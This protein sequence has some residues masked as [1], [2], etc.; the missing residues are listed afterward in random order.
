MAAERAAKQAAKRSAVP[1]PL[2][3]EQA[4]LQAQAEGLTLIKA[5]TKSGYAKVCVLSAGRALMRR[6]CVAVASK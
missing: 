6:R 1:P 3:R 4:L 5:D 2:T